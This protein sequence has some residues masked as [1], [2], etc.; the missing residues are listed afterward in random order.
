VLHDEGGLLAVHD[1]ALDH[2]G[3]GDIMREEGAVSDACGSWESGAD[4]QTVSAPCTT[5][6]VCVC[7]SIGLM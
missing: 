4:D 6:Q 2:L 3:G 5:W 1:E 7:Q